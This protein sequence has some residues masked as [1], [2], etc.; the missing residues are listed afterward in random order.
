MSKKILFIL[1]VG[2]LVLTACTSNATSAP[3]ATEALEEAP[4]ELTG[5]MPCATVYEYETSEEAD[6]YQAVADQLPPLTDE[7]WAR[8]DPN[9]PI[10][11]VEYAD[12]Q[13]PA[14]ANYSLYL[15]TLLYY[16]P[17]SIRVVFRH[18]PL[19]SIHGLAYISSM[20]A[21]AAGA[22]GMFWDMYDLL[23]GQQS[24]WS[25]YTEEEFVDWVKGQ[26]EALGLDLDQFEADMLDEDARAALEATTEERLALGVHYT[27]FVV[28]N[29]LIFTDNQPNLFSLL[30]IYEYGGF[31]SC[32]DW[33]ISPEKS[34][35]ARLDTTAGEIMIDLYAD[36][37]PLAVNSFAFLAENGWFDDVYF[38]SVVEDFVAQAGD[39]S[40]LGV[41][42]PGYTF[43]NEIDENLSFDSAGVLGMA[44]AGA[45]SNGSQFF[46]TL[47]PY[48][49]LDGN[50]TI[51]GKVQED[52]LDVLNQI[53]LRDPDTA[54]SFDGAT[55]I[56]GVEIIEN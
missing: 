47:A 4:V 6:L 5:T 31:E 16:F 35:T 44:N 30:G 39:P 55:I 42:G 17:D 12:F 13:C 26:A 53:A 3:E 45:D 18:M 14:C 36:V 7:D 19:P 9:A 43:V 52:S 22:Q 11:I 29:D 24:A 54:T 15:N 50:Y 49:S 20:A 27:P 56:N 1:L 40:G 2:V 25:S 10:T 48:T 23:Y 28:I 46:I 21:E 37:A 32:P 38:H 8:G 51:F 33:V 34:Y 41:I